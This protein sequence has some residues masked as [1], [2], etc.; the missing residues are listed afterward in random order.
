VDRRTDAISDAGGGYAWYWRGEAYRLSNRPDQ[1]LEDLTRSADSDDYFAPYA[2]V[3]MS[4]IYFGR[5][6]NQ[7]AL[8]ILNRDA[9]L[10]DAN[11]NAASQVALA[12]NNR[13]YAYMQLGDLK[14][15]LDDCTHPLQFGSIP[16]AFLKQQELVRRLAAPGQSETSRPRGPNGQSSP[17]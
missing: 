2:A 14:K 7:G 4:M 9:F 5:N 1:A 3:N 12:Y 17:I 11:R 13:C 16:D 6:D 10:Y 8:N 15:A